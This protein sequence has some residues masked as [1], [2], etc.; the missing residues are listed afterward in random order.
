M[1]K[2]VSILSISFIVFFLFAVES[3]AQLAPPNEAGI[4]MGHVILVVSDL[5]ANVKFWTMLGG[6]SFPMGTATGMKF[7]GGFVFLRK[8]DPTGGGAGSVVDS[9]GFRVPSVPA[10]LINLKAVGVKT[11]NGSNPQQAFIYTPDGLIKIELRGD[12][13]LSVP[14]AFDH[15]HF[16]VAANS[17]SPNPVDDIQAWY[18]KMFGAKAGKKGQFETANIPGAELTFT[19]SDTPTLGTKGRSINQVGFEVKNLETFYKAA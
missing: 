18:V 11:E 12:S 10:F 6:K 4:S 14:I 15:V 5:D 8:A 17:S 3:R 16:S 13:S 9:F 7:P 19:K 2:I 1:K